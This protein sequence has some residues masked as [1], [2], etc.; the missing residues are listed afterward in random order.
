MSVRIQCIPS[1]GLIEMP[2][3]SNVTPLPTSTRCAASGAAYQS[4]RSS[5]GGRAEP[6][7]TA[8][9]PP[10]PSA[11][12]SDSV[13]TRLVSPGSASARRTA[14]SAS[15]AGL[16]TSD[17]VSARSRASAVAA[18]SSAA[19]S[20]TGR[21]RSAADVT[22]VIDGGG[23][24]CSAL[25]RNRCPPSR[26]PC[27]IAASREL[28]AAESGSAS[29]GSR[30][31]RAAGASSRWSPCTTDRVSAAAALRQSRGSPSPI[32]TSQPPPC[33]ASATRCTSPAVPSLPIS[34]GQLGVDAGRRRA[35]AD[36]AVPRRR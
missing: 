18:A 6:D 8:R 2:P 32:P 31:L 15:H 22:S 19:S 16:F 27:T 3:V 7:P 33:D 9:I 26:R 10:N 12:S 13:H 14:S 17:G 1:A 20:A 23:A 25:T 24:G 36:P 11:A 30:Q 35:G 5:R 4:S 28:S 34:A 21:N 29:S